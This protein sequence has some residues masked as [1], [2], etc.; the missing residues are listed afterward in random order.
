MQSIRKINKGDVPHNYPVIVKDGLREKLYFWLI[1]KNITLIALYYR[2]IEPLK[3]KKFDEM[4]YISNNILNLP[5]H[6]DL[7]FKDLHLL[8]TNIKLF[9]EKYR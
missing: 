8:I 4:Q 5:V 9:Y 7:S 3:D 6:Q 2:L 1:D